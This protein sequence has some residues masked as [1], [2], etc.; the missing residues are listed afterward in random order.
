MGAERL[1]VTTTSSARGFI[2]LDKSLNQQIKQLLQQR[3]ISFQQWQHSD[4]VDCYQSAALRGTPLHLGGKSLLFKSRRGFSMFVISAA[5]RINSNRVRKILQQQ[6][7][8]F[9]NEQELKELAGVSKGALPPFGGRFIDC[10]LFIDETIYANQ[11]IVFTCG[12]LTESISMQVSD[13]L[14]LVEGTRVDCCH[15]L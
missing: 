15:P 5:Y 2:K 7:V 13:Y 3:N 14:A 9:A 1:Q 8:R 6:K 10:E 12:S 11:E 4:A